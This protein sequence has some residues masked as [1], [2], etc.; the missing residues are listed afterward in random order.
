MILQGFLLWMGLLAELH[1]FTFLTPH[2]FHGFFFWAMIQD[3]HFIARPV[4][5]LCALAY[6]VMAHNILGQ[7][8]AEVS[9]MYGVT[10]ILLHRSPQVSWFWLTL[11]FGINLSILG[12]I[13][14]LTDSVW[15]SGAGLQRWIQVLFFLLTS[16]LWRHQR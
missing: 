9:V 1:T 10:Q 16:P 3:T 8:L 15:G 14:T 4:C 2:F 13:Y 12:G 5:V 7:T 6:D 11:I